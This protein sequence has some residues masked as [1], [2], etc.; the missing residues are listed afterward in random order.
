ML[1]LL[2]VGE[3][4]AELGQ[5]SLFLLVFK[6]FEGA[7]T[8]NEIAAL[9]IARRQIMM[10]SSHH[11]GRLFGE[12]VNALRLGKSCDRKIAE[13]APIMLADISEAL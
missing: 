13:I 5:L 10:S 2:Q 1:V 4:L 3:Y 11:D 12:P 7:G 9:P 6:F 8:H